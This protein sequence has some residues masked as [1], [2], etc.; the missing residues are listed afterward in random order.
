MEELISEAVRE[1]MGGRERICIEV[2]LLY[3]GHFCSS[4]LK[5]PLP[6]FSAAENKYIFLTGLINGNH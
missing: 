6:E 3:R 5:K 4:S 2:F 1:R